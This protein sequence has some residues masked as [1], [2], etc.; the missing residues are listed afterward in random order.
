LSFKL[1]D[2]AG[3]VYPI[4][5]EVERCPTI[6]ID[7]SHFDAETGTFSGG[8]QDFVASA[9]TATTDASGFLTL[10]GSWQPT[11]AQANA[12]KLRMGFNVFQSSLQYIVDNIHVT[13]N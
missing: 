3:T 1:I 7:P 9:T 12:D 10:T 6:S 2:S 4:D 8:G 11:P 13:S 5:C